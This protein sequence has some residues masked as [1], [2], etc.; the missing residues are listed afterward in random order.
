MRVIGDDGGEKSPL[1]GYGGV[2]SV[3]R[4]IRRPVCGDVAEAAGG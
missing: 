3:G 1:G 4:V 2:G